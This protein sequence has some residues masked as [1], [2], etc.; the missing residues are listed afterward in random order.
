MHWTLAWLG[1]MTL[2][3]CPHLHAETALNGAWRSVHPQDTPQLVLQEYRHGELHSFDPSELQRFQLRDRGVWVVLQAQPPGTLAGQILA[4]NPPPPG[5]VAIYMPDGHSTSQALDDFS[6]TSHAHGWLAWSLGNH[7]KQ[8]GLVLLRFEPGAAAVAP[9]SFTLL[10]P[11]EFLLRDARWLV[12]AS[13]CLAVMLA[14]ALMALCIAPMLRDV[15]FAWYAGFVLCYAFIQGMRSGLLFHPLGMAWLAAISP[16]ATAAAIGLSVSFAALFAVRFCE[17]RRFA[18]LLR[19]PAIGLAVGMLL[20][21]GMRLCPL[22]QVQEAGQLLVDP[23]L[24]LGSI[25]LGI[26]ALSAA[27]QGSRPAWFFLLGWMPLLLLTAWWNGEINGTVSGFRWLGDASLAAGALEALVLSLGLAD[28]ALNMRRTHASVQVLADHDALTNVFNRR[29]WRESVEA[30]LREGGSRPMA[31]LFLDLDHFKVLNDQQGHS[32]GDRALVAV[33]NALR[34]ELR[35]LDRLGRYGGEEFVALLHNT[36]QEQALQV[37]IRLC[38][39][40]HRLE[41]PLDSSG[42]RLSVSIGLAMYQ[43]PNDTLDAWVERADQAMYTAKLGGRNRVHASTAKC[44]ATRT[45]QNL[46]IVE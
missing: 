19:P 18:P 24:I 20:V 46:K 42:G 5:R 6:A 8:N 17:M 43:P 16:S 38:R 37:A 35:P 2:L 12:F 31:L 9:V 36:P 41:I 33:A 21:V 15:T 11:D 23:L 22:H 4:I 7:A 39:R 13:A 32:A 44:A 3:L 10:A 30:A 40:V 27:V 26:A 34:H 45:R 29:A 14:M 28:H 1:L 25:L